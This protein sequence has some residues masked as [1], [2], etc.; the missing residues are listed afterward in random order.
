[1]AG[2]SGRSSGWASSDWPAVSEARFRF[3]RWRYPRAPMRL[4]LDSFWR[5]VAYCMPP[6]VI[7]LSFLPLGLMVVLSAVLGYFYWD[8]AVAW[9]R[10]A[11]DAWPLLSSV[12]AWI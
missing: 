12:W 5:A 4:L 7:V 6:K 2:A 3:P 9:T 8:A 10:Q 11:L 1:M